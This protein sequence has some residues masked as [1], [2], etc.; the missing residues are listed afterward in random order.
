[1]YHWE[2][3]KHLVVKRHTQKRS[4]K[5]LIKRFNVNVERTIHDWLAR[6]GAYSNFSQCIKRDLENLMRFRSAVKDV[7]VDES[8][9]DFLA[10]EAKVLK[11]IG[12]CNE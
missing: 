8:E 6:S 1:M 10:I 12:V 11:K 2:L 5:M 4:P 7:V 9:E 3:T